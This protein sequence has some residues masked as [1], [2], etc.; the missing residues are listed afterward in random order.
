VTV[1]FEHKTV[2]AAPIGLVFDLS[3]DIDAHRTDSL[4]HTVMLPVNAVGERLEGTSQAVRPGKRWSR[5]VA[6]LRSPYTA[7]TVR[8]EGAGNGRALETERHDPL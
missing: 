7:R 3:L 5:P 4:C 1:Q 6:R 2:V 8:W